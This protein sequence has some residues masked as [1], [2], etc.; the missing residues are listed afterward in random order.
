[1]ITFLIFSS[2]LQ[3]SAGNGGEREKKEARKTKPHMYN[4]NMDNQLSGMI[5]HLL[6]QTSYKVGN[7]KADSPPDIVLNGLR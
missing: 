5:F 1:M 7:N 6:D 4:L 3:S 2:H